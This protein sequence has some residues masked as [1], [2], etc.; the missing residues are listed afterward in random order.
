MSSMTQNPTN[1]DEAIKQV[2]TLAESIEQKLKDLS[3]KLDELKTEVE[4]L[5]KKK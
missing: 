5:G 4:K 2:T 3:V 1:L